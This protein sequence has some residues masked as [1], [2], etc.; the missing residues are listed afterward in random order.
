MTNPEPRL[1]TA[2]GRR[3]NWRKNWLKGSFGSIPGGRDGPD[4]TRLVLTL[5]TAGLSV[6]AMVTQSGAVTLRP[7]TFGG[8]SDQSLAGGGVGGRRRG[9][10]GH[11]AAPRAQ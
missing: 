8:S 1:R 4:S 9:G 11:A 3:S 7:A 5:T 6:F 10:G 2:W